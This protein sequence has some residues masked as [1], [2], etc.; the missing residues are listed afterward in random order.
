MTQTFF[1]RPNLTPNLQQIEKLWDDYGM[2]PNIRKHSLAVFAVARTLYH[3][4]ADNNFK[5]DKSLICAG[6]LLHDIAKTI[7]LGQNEIHHDEEGKT[8]LHNRGYYK[9]GEIVA[10]HVRLSETHPLDEAFIIYYADKRV[11]NCDI[12]S[13][14][15]RYDYIV[16][17]YGQKS[18]WRIWYLEQ[19]RTKTFNI[20]KRLFFE[21]PSYIPE[22]LLHIYIPDSI[23]ELNGDLF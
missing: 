10:K 13:I 15:E 23:N 3:W 4:L 9:L 16:D 8:I 14:A 5:F 2:L 7:C 22:D 19:E 21:L 1:E 17:K 11:I 18:T 20:E 12:V 6:A